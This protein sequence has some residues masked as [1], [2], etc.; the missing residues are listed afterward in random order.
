[1]GE[2]GE[3]YFHFYFDDESHIEL[4]ETISRIKFGVVLL[5]NSWT[6]EA[7]KKASRETILQDQ[8]LLSRLLR[9]AIG[10]DAAH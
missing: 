8:K 4:E 9:F 5:H 6:P 3:D 10:I 2:P 7:Y 1:M